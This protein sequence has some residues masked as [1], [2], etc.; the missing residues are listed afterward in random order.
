MKIIKRKEAKEK[1][2]LYYFTGKKCIK[3]HIDKRATSSGT[4][5]T[6]VKLNSSQYSK[7]DSYKL[8]LSLWNKNNPEKWTMYRKNWIENNRAL[9][10]AIN[11]KHRASKEQKTPSWVDSE[12]SFLIQE[13]YDL[14]KIR[15]K[16]TNIK[17]HV[18]HIVPL[19][20]KNVSGLHT[21]YNL[22]V[23]PA[24]V[25]FKKSNKF[26]MDVVI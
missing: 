7:N 1:G 16:Q 23:I 13:V 8:R 9:K 26:D 11:A 14:A 10:N 19:N 4:C 21:I 15:T 18:D 2:L 6:C 22:Q 5:Y 25:N 17:W 20:G 24:K 12:E 3:G